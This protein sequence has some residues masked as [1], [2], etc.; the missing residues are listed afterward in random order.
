MYHAIQD[1]SD[2][3]TP[4]QMSAMDS[5]IET[6][7]EQISEAKAQEKAQRAEFTTLKALVPAAELRL[8]VGKLENKRTQLVQ[9]LTPLRNGAV[10]GGRSVTGEERARVEREWEF[11]RKQA[12][13]R[14]RICRGLWERCT[15]ILP[16]GNTTPKE[17]WEMLGLE[18]E[19]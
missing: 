15:D 9:Q 18:G 17:L 2:G 11:W 12:L 1:P 19:L 13:V 4:E 6:L 7:K 14:R 10:E 8:E 5:E 3:V 16:E